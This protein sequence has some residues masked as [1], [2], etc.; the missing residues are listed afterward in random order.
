MKKALILLILILPTLSSYVSA[1]ENKI[2]EEYTEEYAQELD[3]ALYSESVAK[4]I[5]EIMPGFSTENIIEKSLA[6]KELFNIGDILNRIVSVLFGEIQNL[7]RIMLCVL[8]IS[9][10]M[11]YL[12]ALPDG[13]SKEISE[14]AVYGGYIIIAG[15]CSA[16]FIEIAK[17]GK[18]AIDTMIMLAKII[19]PVVLACLVTSGAVLSATSLQPLLL[20]VTGISLTVIEN[21]FM[22]LVMLFASLNVVSCLSEK[23]TIEK[24]AQFAG[25]TIKWGISL[26]LTVFVGSAGLQSIASGGA[27]GVSVRAAK[28]VTSNLI[29][30][31][32]GILSETVETVLG[33]GSVI[34]NAV[35]ITGIVIMTGYVLLPVIKISACLI[36]LRLTA[37]MV[38]PVGD[39]RVVKCISGLAD[40]V[41]LML[42]GLLAV[43]LMFIIVLTIMINTGGS[44]GGIWR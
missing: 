40:A 6:G 7:I 20:S 42:A 5:E 15:I 27:D 12:S 11:S 35:G 26:L 1:E 21:A 22:P 9:V 24:T 39:K 44:M 38:Q 3:E 31:V 33:C 8:A 10:M 13:R 28:Y 25:K 41:G 14:L 23:F 34:K 16:S 29:P 30:V 2:L 36:V 4:N 43:T 18:D 37:A 17:C 19:V 32:G